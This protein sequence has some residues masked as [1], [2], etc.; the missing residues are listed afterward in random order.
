M[1]ALILHSTEELIFAKLQNSNRKEPQKYNSLVNK[2]N[3]G[4][5]KSANFALGMLK[6]CPSGAPEATEPAPTR[7]CKRRKK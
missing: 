3:F 6:K 7:N 4:H 5:R 2:S 1:K